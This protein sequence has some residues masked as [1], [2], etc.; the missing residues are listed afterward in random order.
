MTLYIGRCVDD[1][2]QYGR[3]TS[4][5]INGIKDAKTKITSRW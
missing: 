1:Y 3:Q 2:E 4:L 5:R